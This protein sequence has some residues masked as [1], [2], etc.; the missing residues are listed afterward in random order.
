MDMMEE[1]EGLWMEPSAS[2]TDDGPES[3]EIEL[4][5]VEAETHADE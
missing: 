4:G 3:Q 2:W 5:R 1:Q